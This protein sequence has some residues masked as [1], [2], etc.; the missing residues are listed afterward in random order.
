M[1]VEGA[2]VFV[3][4]SPDLDPH[5]ERMREQLSAGTTSETERSLYMFLSLIYTT[6]IVKK[7]AICN[8]GVLYD[9]MTFVIFWRSFNSPLTPTG[10][11][12]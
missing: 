2:D 1:I 12:R 10:I 6:N 5:E 7:D 3:A 11:H 9:I 8:V 4:G